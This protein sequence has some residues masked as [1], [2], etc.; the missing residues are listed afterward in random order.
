M[1]VGI[2]PK[3]SLSWQLVGP[4]ADPGFTEKLQLNWCGGG[5]SVHSTICCTLRPVYVD[6]LHMYTCICISTIHIC[7]YVYTIHTCSQSSWSADSTVSKHGGSDLQAFHGRQPDL[8]GLS[9]VDMESWIWNDLPENVATVPLLAL[10]A[11]TEDVSLPEI[12]SWYFALTYMLTPSMMLV[13][14]LVT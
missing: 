5:D 6:I 11:S 13:V 2:F 9:I 10:P 4:P 1:P 7:L 14:M 12:I 3:D 8:S